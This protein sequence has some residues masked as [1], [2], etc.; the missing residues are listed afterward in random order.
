MSREFREYRNCLGD[1]GMVLRVKAGSINP[2]NDWCPWCCPTCEA[3]R[4]NGAV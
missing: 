2:H 1:C 3:R 4:V